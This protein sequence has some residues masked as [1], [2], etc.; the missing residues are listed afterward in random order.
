MAQRTRLALV[1]VR[2]L[3]SRSVLRSCDQV[4]GRDAEASGERQDARQREV[5]LAALHSPD[6]VAMQMR[7]VGQVLLG[8]LE[9][10][11]AASDSCSKRDVG[12]GELGHSAHA[13][14]L[15]PDDLPTT[16]VI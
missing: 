5:V 8:E 3:I 2:A 1:G 9:L 12:I 7:L 16:T 13:A 10:D 4:A 11:A 6:V 14:D 15:T